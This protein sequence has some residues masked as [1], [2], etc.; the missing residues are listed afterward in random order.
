[1]STAKKNSGFT[2]IELLVVMVILG[3]T[4]SLVA[5]DMFSIMKRSQAKTELEKIKAI[6][7]LSIERSFFSVSQLGITFIDNTVVFSQLKPSATVENKVLKTIESEF[8][9]FEETHITI[10][11]GRWQGSHVVKL[12]KSPADKLKE[13]VIYELSDTTK[14]DHSE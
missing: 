1:M 6:T 7:E 14:T 10:N 2:L 5:P 13:L 12:T 9:T 3:I 11:K 8:F 4:S